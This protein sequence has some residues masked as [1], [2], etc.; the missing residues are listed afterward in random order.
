MEEL[1]STTSTP[2]TAM[3]SLE[4]FVR[5]THSRDEGIMPDESI[6]VA[7]ARELLARVDDGAMAE[8]AA[9]ARGYIPVV[10]AEI[11]ELETARAANPR[12]LA[13]RA[14]LFGIATP[15]SDETDSLGW[16]RAAAPR[17]GTV[18]PADLSETRYRSLKTGQ[19]G[20]T[21][22]LRQSLTGTIEDVYARLAD[23]TPPDLTPE[24]LETVRGVGP[25]VARMI[26]A[27]ANPN[28]RVWTVDLWH[29]RQLLWA[30]GLEY[31]VRAS[32]DAVA[33]PMLEACWLAYR[34]DHF[35]DVP[36]WAAQWSTWNAADG[37]H[38]PHHA[39]WADLAA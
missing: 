22:G 32:V 30:A 27:V 11:G 29:A 33:Y 24:R 13:R 7:A 12:E 34:Y 4:T 23:A 10:M 2:E 14:I 38:N 19:D 37:R 1:S 20:K 9:V 8:L 6:G 31:R 18:S 15:N 17:F 39:L 25:K 26:T 36:V 5:R 35:P 28:A 21:I 16:A 3:H